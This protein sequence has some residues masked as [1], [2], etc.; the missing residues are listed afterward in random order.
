MVPNTIIVDLDGTVTS[1]LDRMDHYKT[2]DWD[3]FHEAG[4]RSKPILHVLLT[5]NHLADRGYLVTI[6]TGRTEKYRTGTQSWLHK[7]IPRW[8]RLIMRADNDHRSTVIYKG[9]WLTKFDPRDVLAIF[10]DREAIVQ[11]ARNMGFT[12]FHCMEGAC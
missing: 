8:N 2:R 7:H 10:E 1:Q 9:E 5:V 3:K 12:V 6:I 11:M 4:C